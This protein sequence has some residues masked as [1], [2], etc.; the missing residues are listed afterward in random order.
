MKGSRHQTDLDMGERNTPSLIEQR[1]TALSIM[2]TAHFFCY[3]K[4]K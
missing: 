2:T 3:A 4:H 1:S